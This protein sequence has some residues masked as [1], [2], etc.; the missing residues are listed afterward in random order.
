MSGPDFAEE[1][2]II[3]SADGWE[4]T[5]E[6][7]R[8]S[9]RLQSRIRLLSQRE[10]G[11]NDQHDAHHDDRDSSGHRGGGSEDP[12]RERGDPQEAESL[13]RCNG[14]PNEM[15]LAAEVWKETIDPEKKGCVKARSY[16]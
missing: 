1:R 10:A 15:A 16:R 4:T 13:N 11:L 2:T 6:Q 3:E 12:P 9:R 5:A 7:G 8:F 14:D